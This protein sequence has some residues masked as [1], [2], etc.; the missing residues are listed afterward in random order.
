MAV[1][2]VRACVQVRAYAGFKALAGV[3]ADVME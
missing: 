2:C 1:A 3:T